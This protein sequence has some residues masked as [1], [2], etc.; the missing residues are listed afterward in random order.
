MK[1]RNIFLL[2][3]TA[4]LSVACHS[5]DDPTLEAG[6]ES[7]GNQYIQETNVVTIDALKTEFKDAISNGTLSQI[8]KPTQIKVIVTGNDEGSNIYKQLYVTDGTGSLYVY[9]DKSGLFSEAPVGQCML[10]ELN[11]LYIS[12]YG[13]QPTICVPYYKEG[14]ETASSGRMSRFI[15]QQHFKLISAYEGLKAGLN[16]KPAVI[17]NMKSL[18]LE[19]DCGKLVTLVGVKM[20]D[21]D[22]KNT[23]A[24]SDGSAKLVGGCVNREI[25]GMSDVV[26]RTSTY[27]KFANKIMP[28]EKINITGI[29]SRYNNT[30]QI[31]PR[32]LD[33]ITLTTGKENVDEYEEE[34][35]GTKEEPITVAKA[36]ELINSY[37]DGGTSPSAAIV[38]GK[39][40]KID[41][42]DETHKSITYYISDNGSTNDQIQIYSGKG[43]NGADFTA[44]TDLKAGQTVIVKGTLKKYVNKSGS[45]IPEIDM[46]SEILSLTDGEGGGTSTGSG[47]GTEASPYD[48][49]AAIAKGAATNTWIKGYIV[50]YV[51]GQK[52]SE[53]V[54][55]ATGEVSVSNILIAASP[56]ETDYNKC[57]PVQLP[58]NTDIRTKLN[59]KDNAG[60]LK[61]EVILYGNIEKYFGVV[62]FKSPSYAILNG[63]SIGKNPNGSTGG[64]TANHGT[65]EAP[66]TVAQAIAFID[67]ESNISDAYVKGKISQIDSY[68]AT[69]KSI[70]YWI[71]DDG[72]TTTQL[73]VYSGKGLN[74]ADFSSKEDLTVG[75]TVVIKGN[76]KKFNTTYEFD[77]T[78]SIISI[79]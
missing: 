67:A 64:E 58:N 24:P 14:S 72:G 25:N 39:I 73:Q 40:S 78:S 33:D 74:G 13:K 30:W 57:M 5:W 9:I 75:K 46:S 37:A 49:T 45:V 28:T 48:V 3:L 18:D 35:I 2:A 27:A 12:G 20:K 4:I 77:K 22:G 53:A 51:P 15:W 17:S 55:G 38:K 10:I 62:G 59:L 32:T 68:N 61:K 56:N 65:A 36:I 43:L 23:F 63:T 66:L 19:K 21:A 31:M 44:L 34:T 79:N 6:M 41:K 70:T 60:N 1:T 11:G 42:F 76:L 16:I 69:Y 54:F 7:Y 47:E 50:G 29:A 52:I 8:T 26:V 71:S